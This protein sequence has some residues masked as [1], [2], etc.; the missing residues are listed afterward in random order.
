MS[1][2]PCTVMLHEGQAVLNASE[3]ARTGLNVPDLLRFLE[4]TRGEPAAEDAL[5]LD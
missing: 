4:G 5:K 1:R 2:G 3:H